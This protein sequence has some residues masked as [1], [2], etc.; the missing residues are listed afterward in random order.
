LRVPRFSPD[1]PHRR[2]STR[3]GTSKRV[4]TLSTVGE[5]GGRQPSPSLHAGEE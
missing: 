4:D 1:R 5:V 2:P 3:D